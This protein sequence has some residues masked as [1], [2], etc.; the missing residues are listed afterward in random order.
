MDKRYLKLHVILITYS[1]HT[2]LLLAPKLAV[3]SSQ[4]QNTDITTYR[5][6][7]ARFE[8]AKHQKMIE[9]VIAC[10]WCVYEDV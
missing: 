3:S 1:K 2:Q 7:T 6:N 10:V 9:C 8:L 4:S 5:R